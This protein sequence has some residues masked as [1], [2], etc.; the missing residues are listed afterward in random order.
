M[1]FEFPSSPYL[2]YDFSLL[3]TSNLNFLK[4]RSL[5]SKVTPTLTSDSNSTPRFT[6]ATIFTHLSTSILTFSCSVGALPPSSPLR[7]HQ[8][9]IR[10]IAV[11]TIGFFQ[12]LYHHVN[13]FLKRWSFTS[14]VTPTATPNSD[15]PPRYIHHSIFY[16]LYLH[17]NY[18]LKR[19]SLTSN[20]TPTP[21]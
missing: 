3:S 9:R 11:P 7:K 14:K 20:V 21:T 6:Y 4:R 1:R 17:F 8:F 10:F 19:W 12:P 16:H 15:W 18:F 5:T 2:P 13:F